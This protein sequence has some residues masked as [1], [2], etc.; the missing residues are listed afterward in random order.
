MSGHS[1]EPAESVEEAAVATPDAVADSPIGVPML[2]GGF[3]SVGAGLRRLPPR[4]RADAI[5]RLNR[6]GGNQAVARM[7]QRY[8][9]GPP[10]R[11]PARGLK[12]DIDK[13]SPEEKIAEI[14]R[15]VASGGG[16]AGEGLY[17]VWNSL[18]DLK[19]NATAHADLFAQSA[20]LSPMLLNDPAWESIKSDFKDAVDAKVSANLENNRNYVMDEMK[21]LGISGGDTDD[22][23]TP[24]QD[25]SLLETQKLAEQASKAQKAKGMAQTIPVGTYLMVY[26][27]SGGGPM[28]TRAKVSYSPNGPPSG[29]TGYQVGEGPEFRK[30][31]DI[32]KEYKKADAALQ[33]ILSS[34][35]AVYAL[36]SGADEIGVQQGNTAHTVAGASP[37]DARKQIKPAMVAVIGKIEDAAGKVGGDLDYR[38][39]IPVHEQL[40]AGPKFGDPISKAVI[41]HDVEGHETAKMLRSLGLGALSAAAFI[42][43]EFAT[44]GMATFLLVAAGIGASATNAGLSIDDYMKKKTAADASSGN[45]A[46]DIVNKEQ[47]DSALL[48]AVI[49]SVFVF[50][51]GAGAVAGGLSKGARASAA[52]LEAAEAGLSKS[53]AHGLAEALAKGGEAARTAIEKSVTE[54]GVE[55]TVKASGKTA[56][57]LAEQVGKES[58][59]GK[60]IVAA[61]ETASKEGGKAAE[62][63]AGKLAKFGELDKEEMAKVA[64][65]AL[66]QWGVVGT[67]RRAGG[68]TKLTKALGPEHAISQELMHWR[69]GLIR[70]LEDWMLEESQGASKAVQTGTPKSATSDIDVSM[71]G[72]DASANVKKSREFLASRAG[73]SNEELGKLLDLDVF[74]DPSRMHLQD[75]TKGLS[76]EVRRDI[77]KSAAKYEE[78]LIFAKRLFDAK[79]AGNDALVAQIKADA[80]ALGIKPFEGYKPLGKGEIEALNTR[81]DGLCKKLETASEAEK[82]QIIEEVGQSQGQ[83]LAE[84]GGGYATGGGVRVNVTERP[85]DLPN[86]PKTLTPR[87]PEVRYTAILA[88]GPHLDK[89]AG[90]LAAAAVGPEAYADAIKALGKHGNRVT[91][92]LGAEFMQANQLETLGEQLMEWVKKAKDPDFVKSLANVEELARVR[93]QITGQLAQLKGGS[94]AGLKA[95]R[96]EAQ[97]GAAMTPEATAQIQA[98]T[99]WQAKVTGAATKIDAITPAIFEGLHAGASTMPTGHEDDKK[100]VSV[101]DDQPNQSVNPPGASDGSPGASPPAGQ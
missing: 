100:K 29:M 52:L 18:G 71:F 2:G 51:D 80:E 64:R 24:D 90:E 25:A 48:A 16:A 27:V 3:G 11:D 40:M 35:P 22:A 82:K 7:L 38:D 88:E 55:G 75:V 58:E 43:A 85:I 83:V 84:G 49:D 57:Q 30:W 101:P 34:N 50:L 92:V 59:L 39:F 70:E 17:L 56:D 99:S 21:T 8:A 14:Q 86:M 63:L 45:P 72:E 33:K 31:E 9:D 28:P 1:L 41:Q 12:I 89:A 74:A 76:D 5:A 6:G 46:L 44:A 95:L 26:G 36:V 79:A 19:G 87:W 91:G 15:L 96:E 61:G 69:E 13:A 4:Q 32:D 53:A 94:D 20:R 37:A 42:L 67:V 65:E 47:A 23:P 78:Q 93:E 68:W 73:C 77:S 10:V 66:D 62:E 98:W 81:I 60:R 97:L 54:V